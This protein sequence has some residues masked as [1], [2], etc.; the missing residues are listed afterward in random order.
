MRFH[1]LWSRLF[2]GR[3]VGLIFVAFLV[4]PIYFVSN[5][6]DVINTIGGCAVRM[7]IICDAHMSRSINSVG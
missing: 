2:I 6:R 3:W 4:N 7:P 1:L 5:V